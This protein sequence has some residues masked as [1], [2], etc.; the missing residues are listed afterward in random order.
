M[1]RFTRIALGLACVI[2][3]GLTTSTPAL[4]GGSLSVGKSV[5]TIR[6]SPTKV[7]VMG[8]WAHPDDD[9]SF[10]TGHDLVVDGGVLVRSNVI[11]L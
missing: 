7:D 3:L 1:R 11:D 9:A 5:Q 4:A 8:L 2:A 6:V 10:I